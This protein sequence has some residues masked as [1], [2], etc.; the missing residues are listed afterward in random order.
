MI[1]EQALEKIKYYC[2]YQERCHQEVKDKL[3]E[4]GLHRNEVDEL[5][6]ALIMENFLNE[7]RFAR[8][9][10]GGK[11]RMK[12]WGKRKIISAL[13][14][15]KVSDYCIR[16]GMSEIDE[17]E[18]EKV[19]RKLAEKKYHALRGEQYL[20]R[21]FKTKQYLL[22]KGFEPA[23]AEAVLKDIVAG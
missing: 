5:M 8:A 22:S 2:A 6:A 14:Q 3:Y 1:N 7:E 12:Q 20:R 10:A 15:K 17:K 9:F 18:Y 23:L 19:L 4:M 16:K 11:F 13:R 21:Q